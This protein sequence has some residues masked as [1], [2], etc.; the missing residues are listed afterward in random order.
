MSLIFHMRHEREYLLLQG[1]EGE[2]GVGGWGGCTI[3]EYI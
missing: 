3:L 1:L 2:V